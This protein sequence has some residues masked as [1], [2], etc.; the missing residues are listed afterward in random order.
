MWAVH[1]YVSPC[2]PADTVVS[3][4]SAPSALG[5]Y[6]MWRAGVFRAMRPRG[7]DAS[8]RAERWGIWRESHQLADRDAVRLAGQVGVP[9]VRGVRDGG[10]A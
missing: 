3:V 9:V 2:A 6:P 8:W 1:D 4:V 7:K 5:R 10:A